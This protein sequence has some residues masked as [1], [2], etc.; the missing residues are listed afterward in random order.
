[1][2]KIHDA[3]PSIFLS[4][5]FLSLSHVCA[6]TLLTLHPLI[7]LHD[8]S[9]SSVPRPLTPRISLSLSGSLF[10]LLSDLEP[11]SLGFPFL[12][13][14]YS[15]PPLNVLTNSHRSTRNDPPSLPPILI[16]RL[17]PKHVCQTPY[18]TGAYIY[19]FSLSLFANR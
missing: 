17:L 14:L 3:P 10:F 9:S 16:Y 5:L 13:I 6:N 8:Q 12:S 18:A 1:V 15:L 19:V 11:L 7:S 2:L 4:P